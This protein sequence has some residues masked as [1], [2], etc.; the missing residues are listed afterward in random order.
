MALDW[1]ADAG[2]DRSYVRKSQV[3]DYWVENR[4]LTLEEYEI[5]VFEEQFNEDRFPGCTAILDVI[6]RNIDDEEIFKLKPDQTVKTDDTVSFSQKIE[7]RPRTRVRVTTRVESILRA[8]DVYSFVATA[9]SERLEI[10]VM[11]PPD[12]AVRTLA[13][14]PA[15][16]SFKTDVV[17]DKMI[18]CRLEAGIFPY[19]GI[20]I[21]WAPMDDKDRLGQS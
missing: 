12:C 14:H 8:R 4:S 21:S 1:L 18:V 19:H 5:V 16:E 13:L 10:T 9:A 7:I 11:H 20:E 3:S 15:K 2:I 17:S 6:V